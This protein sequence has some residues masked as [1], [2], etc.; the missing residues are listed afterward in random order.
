MFTLLFLLLTTASALPQVFNE[1]TICNSGSCIKEDLKYE[2]IL[3]AQPGFQ[4]DDAGGYCGSWAIQRAT[5][6]KGAWISQQQVR[7]HTVPGG[8]HDNEILSTNIMTAFQRLHIDVN[9]F[10]YTQPTPQQDA[11]GKWLKQQLVAGYAVTWMILWSGQSY[12]IYGLK[13]PAGMYGHVEP[14]IGI[15]SNH[16][17]NDTT[18]YD[19][20][21]AVHFTDGGVNKVYRKISSLGGK[22]WGDPEIAN[23]APYSY[24]MAKYAFG[25][26][27]KGLNDVSDVTTMPV[28]LQINPWKSEPDIRSGKKGEALQG[29]LTVTGLTIG[30]KYDIYRWDVETFA[31]YTS[32]FLKTSFTASNE[33]YVYVD[34]KSFDSSGTAYYKCIKHLPTE[35]KI[36]SSTAL[37]IPTDDK[38]DDSALT[39]IQIQC[40]DKKCS[41]DCDG[42]PVPQ[43]TCIGSTGGGSAELQCFPNYLQQKLYTNSACSGEPSG[44]SNVTLNKCELSTVGSYYENLCCKQNDPRQICTGPGT[45]NLNTKVILNFI[46]KK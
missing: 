22:L 45:S 23:C 6:T 31:T 32:T 2:L 27:V 11:Y 26:A 40:F 4:W 5:L 24:C 37:K 18:V 17:L 43:N 34:D 16:P 8:G 9:A 12:P 1:T 36:E 44:I 25:W 7:D 42:G 38:L 21:V 10:D 41:Q 29:T 33:T 15:Q 46:K 3:P 35:E 39:Y 28:S 13:A 14:V 30:T 19:D 20:D